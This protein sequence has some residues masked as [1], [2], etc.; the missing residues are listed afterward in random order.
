VLGHGTT[1]RAWERRNESVDINRAI[2]H[3]PLLR[4][5]SAFSKEANE[6]FPY[7]TQNQANLPVH[8]VK[9]EHQLNQLPDKSDHVTEY[10]REDSGV[11]KF[12][13]VIMVESMF[14]PC[15]FVWMSK[16]YVSVLLL[17]SALYRSIS[18]SDV[19]LTTLAR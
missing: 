19:H 18:L 2:S 4:G 11:L 9:V 13:E 15:R 10:S 16:P 7:L 8:N 12:Y 6:R 17:Y 14:C 3:S 1:I 5:P